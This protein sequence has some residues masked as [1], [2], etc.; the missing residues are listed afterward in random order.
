MKTPEEGTPDK[1]R[2]KKRQKGGKTDQAPYAIR[3]KCTFNKP[4]SEPQT[5]PAS[6]SQGKQTHMF[7]ILQ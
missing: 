3:N 7:H 5:V 2:K 6:G 4:P 1:K